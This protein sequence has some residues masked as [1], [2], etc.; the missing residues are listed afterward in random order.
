MITGGRLNV[1]KAIPGCA[2]PPPPTTFGKTSVGASSDFFGVERKRVNR[3]ALGTAGAVTKLSVYLAPTGTAGQQVIKGLVYADSGGAPAGLLGVSEQLTFTSTS[4]TGWYDLTFASPLK[5]AA[6]N[7]WIGVITGATSNVAG[8][9]YDSVAG[10]RDY[11]A[12]TYTSGPTNPFGAV[13]TDAE[14]T[15][16]YATYTPPPVNSAAPTITGTAQQGQTLTEAHGTWT[17]SPTG[18][19]YQ[20]QQCDAPEPTAWRSPAP[21][22]R[23]MCRWPAT[24]ATR[25]GCRRPPA[26]PAAPARRRS[27]LR[28]PK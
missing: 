22:A 9:R 3:Y 28:Q 14:Q 20:W 6:G 12:N 24:S 11:N 10:S 17:N 25:S 8:F 2:T 19:T 13:T 15:S 21:P 26:T 27:Q 16:L 18:F 1:C 5:L 23:P 4:S 7:Y